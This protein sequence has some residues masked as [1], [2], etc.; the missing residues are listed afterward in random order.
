MQPLK[1]IGGSAFSIFDNGSFDREGRPK[2]PSS[3][4]KEKSPLLRQKDSLEDKYTI[5]KKQST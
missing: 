2:P 1:P 4:M 3:L 5:L